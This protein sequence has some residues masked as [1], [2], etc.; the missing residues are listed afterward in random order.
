MLKPT[1]WEAGWN[2]GFS[3]GIHNL[4]E[5][6]HVTSSVNEDNNRSFISSHSFVASEFYAYELFI[7]FRDNRR[8]R[9]FLYDRNEC[10]LWFF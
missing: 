2:I 1:R 6:V 8:N 5:L 9:L 4:N 3:Y 10:K 7:D